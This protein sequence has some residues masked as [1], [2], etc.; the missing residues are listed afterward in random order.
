MKLTWHGCTVSEHPDGSCR[1]YRHREGRRPQ[2]YKLSAH[3]WKDFWY[4][5]L[6]ARSTAIDEKDAQFKAEQRRR[7]LL[8]QHAK[9]TA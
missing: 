8:R 9:K 3:A 1:I 2:V 4:A 6:T 5:V 7:Y